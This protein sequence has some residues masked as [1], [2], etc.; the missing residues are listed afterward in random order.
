MNEA[1]FAEAMSDV[2]KAFDSPRAIVDSRELLPQQKVQLL[3]QWERDLRQLLVAAEENMPGDGQG[4]SAERLREVRQAMA[5][6]GATDAGADT[7]ASFGSGSPVTQDRVDSHRR[8]RRF[9]RHRTLSA[10]APY[11]IGASVA[12]V[13][14]SLGLLA[15]WCTGARAGQVRRR[16]W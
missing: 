10:C 9:G 8:G 16:R 6:L 2:S 5:A 14:V 11:A 15:A 3:E 1:K 13:A 4:G 12:V 7:G